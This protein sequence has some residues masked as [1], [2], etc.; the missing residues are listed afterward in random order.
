MRH[1]L[2]R[3]DSADTGTPASFSGTF[4]D[5]V[6]F[7]VSGYSAAHQLV[8]LGSGGGIL[9]AWADGGGDP[10]DAA[11]IYNLLSFT[12]SQGATGTFVMPEVTLFSSSATTG[13]HAPDDWALCRVS[14]TEI[15]AVRH[16]VDSATQASLGFEHAIWNGSAWQAA[17]APT[18]VPSPF[19]SG[20]V[21]LSDGTPAH[22]IL[23]ATLGEDGTIYT[24]SYHASAASWSTW[25]GIAP[26]A[27]RSALAGTGCG[28]PG[29]MLFWTEGSAS[30]QTIY[31]GDVSALFE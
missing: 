6:Y 10:N 12:Q 14:D 24:A 26:A 8:A 19:N 11:S 1:G 27:A 23:A 7:S 20:L 3:S 13:P 17:A 16:F 15:H 25:Q 18:Q 21:L 28:G 2:Y 31:G 5:H 29:G 22:G 9:A 4:S 30:S